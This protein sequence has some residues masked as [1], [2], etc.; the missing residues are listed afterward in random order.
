MFA[1]DVKLPRKIDE[2][3]FNKLQEDLK[4]IH[5]WSTKWE[6]EFNEKCHTMK[7]G[8]NKNRPSGVYQM[9]G[10]IIYLVKEEKDLGILKPHPDDG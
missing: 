1:D 7:M 6:I 9:G 3:D 4:E 5:K 8:K 10:T 2:D